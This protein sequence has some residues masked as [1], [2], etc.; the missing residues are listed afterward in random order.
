[1]MMPCKAVNIISFN[2]HPVGRPISQ[3][4]K[5][6]SH[7][8]HLGGGKSNTSSILKMVVPDSSAAK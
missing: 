2:E 5:F 4:A 6:I 8:V 1:M 3:C 7:C